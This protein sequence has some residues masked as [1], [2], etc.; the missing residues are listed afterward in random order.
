MTKTPSSH[1]T[2]TTDYQKLTELNTE[3]KLIG[4]TTAVLHWD[5]STQ[6]PAAAGPYRAKQL[7][8][9]KSL[10]HEKLTSKEM[11]DVLD[12]LAT[13][14]NALDDEQKRVVQM[15]RHQFE[16]STQI[17][18]DLQKQLSQIQAETY[19]MW[20]QVRP[21]NDF[22][23]IRPLLEKQFELTFEKANHLKGYA[24]PYDALIDDFD[25]G[26]T[27]EE[28]QTVFSELR[29]KLVPLVKQVTDAKEADDSC[30]HRHYPLE[31]Q[32]E[33]GKSIIKNLGYDFSR[34]RMDK[35][36]HPFC[37]NF[38]SQDVRITYR[39]KEDFL[40]EFLTAAIHES[41]HGMY[42]QGV[43]TKYDGTILAS[44]VSMGVHE[45]QSRLWENL[46]GRSQNFWQHHFP[47]AQKAFPEALGDVTLDEFYKA[48][49]KVQPGLIRVDADELT[50]NLHVMI[51][52]DLENQLFE[53][54]LKFKDLPEAWNARYK[55]DLGIDV[56]EVK[57]GVMQDVHW[58]TGLW[59]YFPSYTLGN[60]MSAQFF[61]A[62]V[63]AHSQI[64]D[65][66]S[67]G[68]FSTLH[69]WLKDNVY[70]HGR[71]YPSKEL[72]KR[73]T[74]SDLSVKPFMDYSTKKYSALYGLS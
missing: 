65:E 55:S 13:Q 71:R 44:G 12:R 23:K 31:A 39:Y 58:Y 16:K 7:A 34:G 27:S 46:V 17:P 43:N 45:S 29:S 62:A 11:G 19:Q 26:T 38:S 36:T 14:E 57:D 9:L 24:T 35:T 60:L 68:K 37:I 30:L 51:R 25:E 6:M 66:I 8:V 69:G 48:M 73:A 53:G 32:I 56:T 20:A 52:F 3:I 4:S 41:G 42:E 74:G 61:D 70:Q 22:E 33:F 64:P 15:T 21:E 47:L 67:Q 50:Y 40:N 2:M 49:N 54:Q 28:I 72:L 59:G 18:A 63:Q 1:G 10:I 5:Q